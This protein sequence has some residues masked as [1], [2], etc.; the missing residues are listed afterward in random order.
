[1]PHNSEFLTR[2]QI[3]DGKLHTA[4]WRIAP[5]VSGRSLTQYERCAVEEFETAVDRKER[6]RSSRSTSA[7]GRR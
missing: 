5:Y 6:A 7:R 1:M 4:G 2:K 3:I